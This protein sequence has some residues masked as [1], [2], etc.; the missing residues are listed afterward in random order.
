MT[1]L[2]FSHSP[3]HS[4]V[5]HH[6]CLFRGLAFVFHLS[7]TNNEYSWAISGNFTRLQKENGCGTVCRMNVDCAD[8][9]PEIQP[10]RSKALQSILGWVS[11][12]LALSPLCPPAHC[13]ALDESHPAHS[14]ALSPLLFYMMRV[15]D[16]V[17]GS[18]T[19]LQGTH[20]FHREALGVPVARRH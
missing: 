9:H 20:G 5:P 1:S 18:Q 17:D 14:G 19:G 4:I 13:V 10:Q 12:A 6:G 8:G 11:R 15:Q 2:G 3:P 16:E 7:Q